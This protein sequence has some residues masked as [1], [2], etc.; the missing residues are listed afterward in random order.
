M[1]AANPRAN[2]VGDLGAFFVLS[3]T[4]SHDVERNRKP[5]PGFDKKPIQTITGIGIQHRDL[6]TGGTQETIKWAFACRDSTVRA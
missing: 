5:Q 4:T 3:L 2:E 1:T 6:R